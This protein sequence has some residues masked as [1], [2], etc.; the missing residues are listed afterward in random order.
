MS[1]PTGRED[2]REEEKNEH[3]TRTAWSRVWCVNA[4]YWLIEAGRGCD[5]AQT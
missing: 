1:R 5:E 2:N 3:Q 4:C